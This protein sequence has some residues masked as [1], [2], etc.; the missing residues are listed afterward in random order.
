MATFGDEL[1]WSSLTE[2]KYLRRSMGACGQ[3]KR[4]SS[5]RL[6][7]MHSP[8]PLEYSRLMTLPRRLRNANTCTPDGSSS[9]ALY[10]AARRLKP[11]RISVKPAVIQMRGPAGSPI[12]LTGSGTSMPRRLERVR[13]ASSLHMAQRCCAHTAVLERFTV[14][15]CFCAPQN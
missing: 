3:T 11:Q 9:N 6:A 10:Q 7:T 14:L 12:M 13:L 15:S 8:S 1:I 4:P 2:K 5:R